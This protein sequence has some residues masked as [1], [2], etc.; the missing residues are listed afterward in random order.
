[1]RGA[2]DDHWR[3]LGA[4]GLAGLDGGSR[5]HPL[6]HLIRGP[7]EQ[8][9]TLA[10]R[11]CHLCS[12]GVFALAAQTTTWGFELRSA[13]ESRPSV[14]SCAVIVWGIACASSP[15][16]LSS[17]SRS[18]LTVF[19]YDVCS[20]LRVHATLRMCA[21]LGIV[22]RVQGQ[23]EDLHPARHIFETLSRASHRPSRLCS[24]VSTVV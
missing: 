23:A 7:F 13:K 18:T 22:R 12:L 16:S 5:R 10:M 9:H 3:R 2:V 24:G 20:G 6:T 19:V 21:R 8:H 11:S 14:Y 1:M 15:L 4:R 17:L